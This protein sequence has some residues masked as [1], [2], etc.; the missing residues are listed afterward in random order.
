MLC[1]IYYF[2]NIII[3]IRTT[4]VARLIVQLISLPITI[5]TSNWIAFPAEIWLLHNSLGGCT[6]QQTYRRG[7]IDCIQN[8]AQPAQWEA[9]AAR[10]KNNNR[11][12][13]QREN[14]Q[15][16][17]ITIIIIIIISNW[18]SWGS[19]IVA[20]ST[21]WRTHTHSH[22]DYMQVTQFS[23]H[24]KR[25]HRKTRSELRNLL[26]ELCVRIAFEQ[27]EEV[28]KV[29]QVDCSSGKRSNWVYSVCSLRRTW[30]ITLL[31]GCPEMQTVVNIIYH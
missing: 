2:D 22:V 19:A 16:S 14:R 25:H 7:L 27:G 10:R 13:D 12:E 3:I 17:N 8:V 5:N 20:T 11:S 6:Q 9:R 28:R 4:F 18:G 29:A 30:G 15:S 23:T 24:R 26:F 1:Y 31:N 21:E